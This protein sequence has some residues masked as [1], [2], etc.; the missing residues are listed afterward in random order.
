MRLEAVTVCVGL[1]DYLAHSLPANKSL[2]D[3]LVVVTS[4]D[5]RETLQVAKF[6]HVE[7]LATDCMFEDNQVFNKGKAVNAGLEHVRFGGWVVQLDVD[8][9]LPPQA[10]DVLEH[11]DL[12][13]QFLYGVDRVMCPSY[14]AWQKY[15]ANPEPLYENG[16]VYPPPFPLDGRL[17]SQEDRGYVPIG[18][19]QLF[20]REANL[21]DP[22][23]PTEFD[24]AAG[25]DMAFARKFPRTHR[26]LLPE[27]Y[28]L[29]LQ[30]EDST[31]AANWQ[32]RKTARFAPGN[33]FRFRR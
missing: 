3:R 18:F 33:P 20:H 13:E 14:E 4:P 12:C 6:F 1:S 24:T 10:R 30:T 27:L 19:F 16:W 25:S 5:D 32:G 11:V 17:Y 22:V 8:I 29:H 31:H 9:V 7:S 2:F 15:M 23:Y 21:G 28:A 26:H